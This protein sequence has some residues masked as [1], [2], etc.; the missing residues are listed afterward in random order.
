[1]SVLGF[2]VDLT[3]S[4]EALRDR[5]D[6]AERQRDCTL[7]NLTA[8]YAELQTMRR[9]LEESEQLIRCQ[10]RMLAE[11]RDERDGYIRELFMERLRMADLRRWLEMQHTSTGGQP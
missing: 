2:L 10:F 3:A 1:M 7:D 9:R 5:V 8:A 6:T 4:C 11:M